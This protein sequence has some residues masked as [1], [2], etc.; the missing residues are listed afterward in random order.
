MTI[1]IDSLLPR[2]EGLI[3]HI[4]I[5]GHLPSPAHEITAIRHGIT[6]HGS[7]SIS[8]DTREKDGMF[9]QVMKKVRESVNLGRVGPGNYP[10]HITCNGATVHMG[11]IAL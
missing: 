4:D 6:Q 5:S 10:L 7:I 11:K 1:N 3:A 8:I 2:R 9:P